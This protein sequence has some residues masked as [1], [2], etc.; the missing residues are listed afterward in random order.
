MFLDGYSDLLQEYRRQINQINKPN[1]FSAISDL[2]K[3]E[4]FTSD[5]ISFILNPNTIG[6]KYLKSFLQLIGLKK[7]QIDSFLQNKEEVEILREEHRIDILIRNKNDAIIVE[8][9]LNNAPDQPIQLVRYYD[10]LQNAKNKNDK[11]NV[12]K[13]VYLTIEPKTP[14]LKY[15]KGYG[16]SKRKFS[17]LKKEITDK[18]CK[19]CITAK[20][21]EEYKSFIKIFN[22]KKLTESDIAVQFKNLLKIIEGETMEAAKNIIEKIFKNTNNISNAYT[23]EEIWQIRGKVLKDIF[24]DNFDKIFNCQKEWE[25][26]KNDCYYHRQ[27]LKQKAKIY[28]CPVHNSKEKFWVQIGFYFN[29]PTK[30]KKAF[31]I[32]LE[33]MVEYNQ[34]NFDKENINTYENYWHC[35][36]YIYDE[37]ISFNEYISNI[38]KMIDY[39]SANN[40]A[41]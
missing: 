21:N 15:V 17:I 24:E 9:K 29:N 6:E 8:S 33:N 26:K 38:K 37:Q 27:K 5:I 31:N 40:K 41:P 18:L 28:L 22:N 11:I 23:F 39:L 12:L 10:K 13:V 7:T 36:E 20:E 1:V 25:Q 19:V 30:N 34:I 32:L 35:Y 4:N 3:R 16:F 2:Y 14:D